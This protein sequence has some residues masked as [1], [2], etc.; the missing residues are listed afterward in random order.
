MSADIGD[1]WHQLHKISTLPGW[2][3]GPS[4]RAEA[5]TFVLVLMLS[6][7]HECLARGWQALLD[8]LNDSAVLRARDNGSRNIRPH[9]AI[10]DSSLG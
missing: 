5:F 10:L 8:I 2:E 9:V 6:F 1:I 3:P 4:I 7:D